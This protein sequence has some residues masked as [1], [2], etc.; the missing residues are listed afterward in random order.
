[1]TARATPRIT[2]AALERAARSGDLFL[3]YQPKLDLRSGAIV[4]IEALA[5]WQHPR[6]GSISP[7][8][9]I[10][11]IERSGLIDWFTEWALTAATRQWCEWRE[12]GLDLELAVNI[13]ALNLQ[14]LFFPDLVSSICS[15]QGVPQD[16]LTL[17][18]TEG[19]TQEATRLM[20]AVARFRLKGIGIS[21]DDFGTGY[22]S[23]VQLRCL[24]FTELKID[25]RFV[26]DLLVS[27]DS[28]AI[29]RGLIAMAHEIGLTVTAEGVEDQLTLETLRAFGCDKAQGYLIA[30]PMCGD[31]LLLW[32]QRWKLRPEA[33]QPAPAEDRLPCAMVAGQPRAG[34]ASK[35]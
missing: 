11:A 28:R 19:S 22:G 6:H 24:P 13:S 33:E 10:P 21:L 8:D 3:M 17:E 23:L 20:D 27:R 16:R 32:M 35:T 18:L 12:Q 29:S 14:H 34:I 25:R 15:D 2:L 9:F 7:V 31:R 1:M 26:A 4:G 30:R 5:R